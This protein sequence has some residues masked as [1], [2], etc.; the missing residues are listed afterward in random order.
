MDAE[1]HEITKTPQLISQWNLEEG[2]KLGWGILMF[3][4][5]ECA[6]IILGAFHAWS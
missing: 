5:P 1:F 4:F 6:S 3:E 2:E